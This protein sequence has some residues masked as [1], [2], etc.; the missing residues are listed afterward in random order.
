M[1]VFGPAFGRDAGLTLVTPP[2]RRPRLARSLLATPW[3]AAGA[4]IVIAAVLAVNSPAALTYGPPVEKCPIHGCG[5]SAGHP[6]AQPATASPGVALKAPGMEMNRGGTAPV[7]RHGHAARGRRL[8]YRI[9]RRW[10]S[11][12]L[13]LIALPGATRPGGW[14]L[15]FAFAAAH[16]DR[17]WGARWQP[18]GNGDGGT[19]AGPYGPP[20]DPLGADQMLVFA[21]GTPELPSGC[22]LDGV[23][24]RFSWDRAVR[25]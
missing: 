9:V 10:S 2:R 1:P 11:G 19:A 21:T 23:R 25:D 6:P 17:V 5:S 22:A 8:G 7:R 20:G 18:S 14:S 15:S 16:V 24:C 12:F 3:F 13:A 4:G